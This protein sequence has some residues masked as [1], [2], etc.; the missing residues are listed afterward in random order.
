MTFQV[1]YDQ[2]EACKNNSLPLYA[3]LLY[4]VPLPLV[5]STEQTKASLFT[6]TSSVSVNIKMLELRISDLQASTTRYSYLF[7]PRKITS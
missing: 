6:D 1:L 7:T 4:N 2:H 3:L 5:S